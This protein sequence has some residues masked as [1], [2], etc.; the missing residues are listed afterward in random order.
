M[1]KL[2]HINSLHA[3]VAIDV[4]QKQ[5]SYLIFFLQASEVVAELQAVLVTQPPPF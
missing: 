1:G 3:G 5:S 4:S 2:V